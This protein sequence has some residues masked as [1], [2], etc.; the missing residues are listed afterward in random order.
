MKRLGLNAEI[1]WGFSS[2]ALALRFH[3]DLIAI[4]GLLKLVHEHLALD[5]DSRS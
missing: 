4:F 3:D 5:R 1:I 2:H